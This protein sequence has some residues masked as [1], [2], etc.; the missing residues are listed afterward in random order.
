MLEEIDPSDILIV[1][2]VRDNIRFLSNFLATEGYTVRKATTGQMALRAIQALKPDLILLDIRMPDIDG[3]E[4]CRQLKANPETVTIPIIFLSAGDEPADRAKAFQVGGVDYIAKPFQL[5]EILVRI[6]TQLRIQGLQQQLA[7]QQ[8]AAPTA[9]PPADPATIDLAAF[10]ARI[11]SVVDEVDEPLGLIESTIVAVR[12]Q[13][14][15][16]GLLVEQ[17]QPENL[18]RLTLN[19]LGPEPVELGGVV[20]NLNT[21]IQS[22]EDEAM[23]SRAILAAF[24]QIEAT[25]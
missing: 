3:Y 22:I 16:L 15:S 6:Q 19:E 23:R 17:G 9:S 24:K 18:E 1:D 8:Q 11:A 21:L 7:R 4:I 2:D 20:S 5:D 25:S 12:Q 13:V 14:R 10:Q